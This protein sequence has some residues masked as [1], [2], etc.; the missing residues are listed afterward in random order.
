MKII[1][2]RHGNTFDPS[3]KVVWAGL[4][5]DFS[6]VNAGREQALTLA[7]ALKE[8]QIIPAKIYSGLLKRT[9]E[10]SEI[11]ARQLSEEIKIDFD[12]RLNEINY[13][14]FGG[15]SGEEIV[16]LGGGEALKKWDEESIWATDYFIGKESQIID[17]VKDFYH[18]LLEN[19]QRSDTILVVSSNGILRYFLKL[20]PNE[21]EKRIQKR[22]FKIKTGHLG[23]IECAETNISLINW[24]IS[25]NNL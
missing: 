22:D 1:L 10:Y 8:R 20:I 15:K 2:A 18:A 6:L 11:I 5:Q 23:M 21:F 16:S 25:P 3:D 17:G 14:S 7:N 24:N 4:E 9:K 13:G 12:A 19:H